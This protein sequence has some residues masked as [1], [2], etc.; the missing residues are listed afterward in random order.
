MALRKHINALKDIESSKVFA[1]K[2]LLV[3]RLWKP[4]LAI[5]LYSALLCFLQFEAEVIEFTLGIE[6]SGLMSAALGIYLVFRNRTAYDRWWEGRII[7]GMLVNT[8]RNFAL[9]INN[10]IPSGNPKIKNEFAELISAFPYALKEH[11]RTGVKMEQISFVNET[12]Y[13][14]IEKQD[15]KPN[16]IVNIMVKKLK[17]LYDNGLITDYQLGY[18]IENTVKLTDILGMCERIRTTPIPVSHNFLLKSFLFLYYL[19]LPPGLVYDLGWW[20]IP[21]AF[22]VTYLLNSM[23]LIDEDIEEPFGDDFNDLPTDRISDNISKN[24]GEILLQD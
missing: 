8:S 7:W 21:V 10:L 4:L 24:V 13:A 2:A 23:V 14:I 18:L 15:H 11:L 1:F 16:A 22:M 17:L 20:T 19:I 9:Q 6:I 3:W 12:N 5:G